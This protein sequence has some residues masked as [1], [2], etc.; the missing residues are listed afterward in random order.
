LPVNHFP[1]YPFGTI[2]W[3]RS[4]ALKLQTTPSLTNALSS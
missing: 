1:G 2:K 4:S 3:V